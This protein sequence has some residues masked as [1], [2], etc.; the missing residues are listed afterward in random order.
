[1]HAKHMST[2]QQQTQMSRQ[3]QKKA[4]A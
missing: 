1:M 3:T 4:D 2:K